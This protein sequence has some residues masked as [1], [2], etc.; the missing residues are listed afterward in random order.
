MFRATLPLMIAATFAGVSPAAAKDWMCFEQRMG[1]SVIVQDI[2]WGR[3]CGSDRSMQVR[4]K[5]DALFEQDIQICL[6]GSDG[7]FRCT[8]KS[9]VPMGQVE[10][11]YSC[12]FG[13][14]VVVYTR[15]SGTNERFPSAREVA[16]NPS[17]IRSCYDRRN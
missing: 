11:D 15:A 14:D 3:S 2:Q 12:N 13:G 17:A 6:Q 4:I 1:Y 8:L 10:S 5:N 16:S 7:R 9:R